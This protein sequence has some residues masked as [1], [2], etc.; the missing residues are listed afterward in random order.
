MVLGL[1]ARKETPAEAAGKALYARVVDQARTPALY[2]H[3]AAHDTPMGRF[4][5]YTLHTLLLVL[6]LKG[7]GDEAQETVQAMFDAYIT[8]LD[9]GL[10][11]LGVGHNS[12][13]KK[14]KKLGRAFYGRLANWETALASEGELEPLIRRTVY[15]GDEAINPAPMAAYV[16]SVVAHLAQQSDEVL[17]Q[18]EVTWPKVVTP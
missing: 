18:G 9:I 17:L 6:R 15:E 12:L 8:G 11:E 3:L 7:R 4:E 14:M 1:F 2:R 10:L 13:G 5:V 16:R